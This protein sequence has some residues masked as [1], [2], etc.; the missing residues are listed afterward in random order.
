MIAMNYQNDYLR[1]S[2][3]YK[4]ILTSNTLEGEEIKKTTHTNK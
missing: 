2:Y 1:I 4:P 3:C